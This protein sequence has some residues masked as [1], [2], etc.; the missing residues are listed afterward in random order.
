[1]PLVAPGGVLKS[2]SLAPSHT[3][4]PDKVPQLST[5]MSTPSLAAQLFHFLP[6]IFSLSWCFTGLPATFHASTHSLANYVQ[7]TDSLYMANSEWWP[8]D[9]CDGK[10]PKVMTGESDEVDDD[11]DDRGDV[12]ME[13]PSQKGPKASTTA[14]T[15]STPPPPRKM[16]AQANRGSALF[17]L[18]G[19]AAKVMQ[20]K[21]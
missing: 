6:K 11:D 21:G 1:M 16:L 4:M 8:V 18:E 5:F 2:L 13:T 10:K 12:R 17:A 19:K 20:A 14:R 9:I 3:R 15:S 7:D